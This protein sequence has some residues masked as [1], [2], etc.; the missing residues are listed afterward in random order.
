MIGWLFAYSENRLAAPVVRAQT[1]R[2]N[3][4][5]RLSGGCPKRCVTG[6]YRLGWCATGCGA[7]R[8]HPGDDEDTPVFVLFQSKRHFLTRSILATDG[9][10]G[11]RRAHRGDSKQLPLCFLSAALFQNSTPLLFGLMQ[12]VV[13]GVRTEETMADKALIN[14]YDY[15]GIFGTGEQSEQQRQVNN[16]DK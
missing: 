9:R 2:A 12:G 8:A 3:S 10:C 11:V 14:R 7:W 16:S 4:V 1:L 13:Y 6:V 15:D 5:P